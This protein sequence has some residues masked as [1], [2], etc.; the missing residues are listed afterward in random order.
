M[1]PSG[2]V[3][4]SSGRCGLRHEVVAVQRDVE[5]AMRDRDAGE[6]RNL[7]SQPPGQRDAAGRDAKQH[8]VWR[9]GHAG[10]V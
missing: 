4:F 10:V 3:V 1:P 2:I 9:V 7:G 6:L 8:D 5:G